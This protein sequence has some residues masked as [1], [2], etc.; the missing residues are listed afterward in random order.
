MGSQ[1]GIVGSQVGQA[2]SQ[3]DVSEC[4]AAN[5]AFKLGYEVSQVGWTGSKTGST[6]P[7]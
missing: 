1:V 4:Q 2:V 5:V 3:V 7:W 6:N